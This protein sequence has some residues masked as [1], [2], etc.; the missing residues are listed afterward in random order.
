VILTAYLIV[1]LFGASSE[2]AKKEAAVLKS[3]MKKQ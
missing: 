1:R 2:E 3:L